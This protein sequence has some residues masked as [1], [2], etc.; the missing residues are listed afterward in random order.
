L[1][2][3]EHTVAETAA[4]VDAFHFIQGLRLRIQAGAREARAGARG[5]G[6]DLANRIDPAAL[7]DFEQSCLK[8]ALRLARQLQRRLELDFQV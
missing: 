4:L 1:R 6:E 5:A 8:E 3:I 7:N 2:E